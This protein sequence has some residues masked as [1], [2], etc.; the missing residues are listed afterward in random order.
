MNQRLKKLLENTFFTICIPAGVF[1]LL[2]ILCSIKGIALFETANHVRTFINAFA[3]TTI[4]A[5]A[6]NFN[7]SSGRFDFSLGSIGLLSCIIGVKLTWALADAGA[8]SNAFIM[9]VIIIAVG[10]ILGAISGLVYI[11]L[12]IAPIVTSLGITLIYEAF[13]FI[14]TGGSGVVLNTSLHLTKISNASNQIVILAIGFVCIYIISNFTRF[15]YEW[16]SLISGQKISVETGIKEKRNALICYILAGMFIAVAASFNMSTQGTASAALNFS[17]ISTIFTAFLPLF[18][19]GFIKRFS[20]EKIGILLGSF[21]TALITLGF[22]RL[23]V[24]AQMQSLWNAI[25][26]LLFLVYLNNEGK[27]KSMLRLKKN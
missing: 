20:E 12:N 18:L 14:V 9:L 21:T 1:L 13:T 7:L 15:G 6:L 3:V 8:P 16:R 2:V 17:T 10:A 24:S 19:G 22:V 25:I 23:D 27:L 4:I 11:V 5:W 26:L